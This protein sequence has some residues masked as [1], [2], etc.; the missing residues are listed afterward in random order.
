VSSSQRHCECRANGGFLKVTGGAYSCETCPEGTWQGPKSR[1]IYEC[2]ACEGEGKIYDTNNK[3]V[4]GYQCVCD[5][6]QDYVT[7]GDICILETV[8]ETVTNL[9][10]ASYRMTYDGG[11]TGTKVDQQLTVSSSDTLKQLYIKSAVGC[12]TYNQIQ[13]C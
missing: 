6:S 2:V 12:Q 11:V 7:A 10:P 8:T 5:K 3:Q 4:D 13:D 9:Y 1:P